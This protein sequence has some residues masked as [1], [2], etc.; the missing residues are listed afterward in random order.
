MKAVAFAMFAGC[1]SLASA[2]SANA[3]QSPAA[4]VRLPDGETREARRLHLGL[5]GPDNLTRAMI[6]DDM[7]DATRGFLEKQ[8]AGYDLLVAALPEPFKPGAHPS[9]EERA[10]VQHELP[11]GQYFSNLCWS[12]GEQCN[13]AVVSV[14][15]Y[16]H[17]NYTV[18]ARRLT[19]ATYLFRQLLTFQAARE[20][21]ETIKAAGP[22]LYQFACEGLEYADVWRSVP[23]ISRDSMRRSMRQSLEAFS[24]DDAS[25]DA[26][27][28]DFN[29]NAD[30]L[31]DIRE[32]SLLSLFL[33]LER[34]PEP[35]DCYG[36]ALGIGCG[37]IRTVVRAGVEYLAYCEM[38]RVPGSD[39][40]YEDCFA[41]ARR[42][43]GGSWDLA[44]VLVEH[45][46]GGSGTGGPSSSFT[47][48]L[49]AGDASRAV[50]LLNVAFV[51]AVLPTLSSGVRREDPLTLVRGRNINW[52]VRR[53][54]GGGRT[55]AAV[56]LIAFVRP[57]RTGVTVDFIVEVGFS[58]TRLRNAR[59]ALPGTDAELQGVQ[60]HLEG[61]M[62]SAFGPTACEWIDGGP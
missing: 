61:R 30:P 10:A 7:P 45:V 44:E 57:A 23:D 13:T 4:I 40:T 42:G 9:P 17:Y 22:S 6:S 53:L 21:D 48:T 27:V 52:N 38:R 36:G 2:S 56:E 59:D 12:S 54:V 60:E 41:I 55:W 32:G 33:D 5:T 18:P 37:V 1:L 24:M 62:R 14:E 39:P 49:P 50:Q 26:A 16:P 29:S 20:C 43:E 58:A 35:Q 28:L 47:C 25:F 31:A 19:I 34:Q 3:A 8:A 15:D 51:P 11:Q 46:Y